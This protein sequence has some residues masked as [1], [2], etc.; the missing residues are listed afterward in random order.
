MIGDDKA[1]L[2]AK[3]P[4][5]HVV[6]EEKVDGQNRAQQGAYARIGGGSTNRFVLLH[7]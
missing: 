5:D 3:K 1:L 2:K 4:S 7:R 6:T